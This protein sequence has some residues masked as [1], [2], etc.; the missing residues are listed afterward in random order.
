MRMHPGLV[1]RHDRALGH[2]AQFTRAEL[3]ERGIY[4]MF[5]WHS[6]Q[7]SILLRLYRIRRKIGLNLTT[8]TYQQVSS[9]HMI[10]FMQLCKR[11]GFL[12][13]QNTL[14]H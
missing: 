3:H 5:G 13:Y 4:P 2:S 14:I 6:H 12:L 9:I 10:S 11:P 8:Q 7:I 1:F